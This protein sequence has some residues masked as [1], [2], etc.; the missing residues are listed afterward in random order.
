MTTAP[1]GGR[2][3]QDDT[4]F[5]TSVADEDDPLGRDANLDRLRTTYTR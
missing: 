1:N 3:G 4:P 2:A 5:E